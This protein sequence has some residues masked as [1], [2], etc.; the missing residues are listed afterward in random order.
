MHLSIGAATAMLMTA[1]FFLWLHHQYTIGV[2]AWFG[3]ISLAVVALAGTGS[4]YV[5]FLIRRALNAR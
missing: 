3:I 5:V 1:A 4:G 2:D